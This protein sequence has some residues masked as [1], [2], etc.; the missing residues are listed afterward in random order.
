MASSGAGRAN[1]GPWKPPDTHAAK[2]RPK[3]HKGHCKLELPAPANQPPPRQPMGYAF[4]RYLVAMD[5]TIY[6]MANTAFDRMLRDPTR[7][8]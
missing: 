4:H 2:C 7:C 5:D 6:R 3:V 1:P 8:R